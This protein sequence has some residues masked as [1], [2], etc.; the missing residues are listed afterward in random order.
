MIDFL[1]KTQKR[2]GTVNLAEL[3][4]FLGKTEG[5]IRALQKQNPKKFEMLYM[6]AVCSANQIDIKKLKEL[7]EQQE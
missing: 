5:T 1:H 4:N 2:A 7:L 6:G 3:S